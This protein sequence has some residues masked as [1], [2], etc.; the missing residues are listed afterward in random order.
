MH[1]RIAKFVTSSPAS[2]K[3]R[4]LNIPQAVVTS[5]DGDPRRQIAAGRNLNR[6]NLSRL[7][8][9]VTNRP[10]QI[11]DTLTLESGSPALARQGVRLLIQ[12]KGKRGESLP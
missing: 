7:E 12:H 8:T 6:D 1:P 3:R 5:V 10:E 4:S 9:R 2:P 11:A